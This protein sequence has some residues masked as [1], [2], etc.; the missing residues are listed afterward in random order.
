MDRRSAAV[1]AAG[2]VLAAVLATGPILA[3][4]KNVWAEET[5]L[6]ISAPGCAWTQPRSGGLGR[7]LA[8]L[9]AGWALGPRLV[10][11]EEYRERVVEIAMEDPDV[12][13]LVEEGFNVTNVRPIVRAY[14]GADG[15]VSLRADEALVVLRKDGSVAVVLVSLSE[16][17]VI[18]VVVRT[19]TVVEK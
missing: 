2:L 17:R 7:R 15:S 18:K 6:Q 19:V 5:P 8:Q 9:K 16:E 10:V 1:L 3:Y 12:S 14:V 4:A 11:S 13:K